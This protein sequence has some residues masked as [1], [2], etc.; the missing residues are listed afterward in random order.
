[1]EGPIAFRALI[2]DNFKK[3]TDIDYLIH[4]VVVVMYKFMWLP[5]LAVNEG[6]IQL[7]NWALISLAACI[8]PAGWT[9]PVQWNQGDLIH[10]KENLLESEKSKSEWFCE[11]VDSM[12]W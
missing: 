3:V 7:G 5:L 2:W 4:F 11:I 12:N 8:V 10:L 6:L 9:A 1:M